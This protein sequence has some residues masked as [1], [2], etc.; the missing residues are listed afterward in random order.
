MRPGVVV[1]LA[2]AAPTLAGCAGFGFGGE[3]SPAKPVAAAAARPTA[4][5]VGTS[6]PAAQPIAP[7]AAVQAQPLPPAA[8][9][10]PAQ[11]AQPVAPVAAAQVQPAKSAA[12]AISAGAALGGALSGPIGASLT[13]ADREAAWKAQI[14]ALE[15]RPTPLVAR[16][17][18]RFRFCRTRGR[19]RRRLSR[20]FAD[21]LSRRAAE[22]RPGCCL[23]TAG[24]RLE[25]DELDFLAR[26]RRRFA[27]TEREH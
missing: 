16:R 15:F 22:T 12:P 14:A 13:E 8:P 17:T 6:T 18:R 2:L 24:R 25:I 11:A 5:A 21:H 26:R 9:A 19:N 3:A 7:V 1:I 27:I 10:T 20:L 23:Q 4:P